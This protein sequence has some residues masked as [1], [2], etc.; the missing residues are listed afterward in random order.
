MSKAFETTLTEKNQADPNDCLSRYLIRHGYSPDACLESLTPDASTRKYFRIRWNDKTAVVA[1]YPDPFDPVN[2]SFLD[3]T[4]LL[5]KAGLPV[6]EILDVD[7][8]EGVIVQEDLGD[9]QL[10]WLIQSADDRTQISY[11]EKAICLIAKIQAATQLAKDENSIASHLAFDEEKLSWE[12]NF[13]FAHYFKSLRG[14]S[15]SSP[16]E[17]EL[18]QE[19]D[20]ISRELSGVKRVL[21]HRDFH[22]A[23][24]MVDSSSILRVVDYQDARMGPA[25]YDLVS[26]LLDRQPSPPSD[27]Q[28]RE[29]IKFFLLEREKIGLTSLDQNSFT[30]E[31]HLMTL[32]RELK[33]AG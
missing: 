2:Q 14:E 24:L 6:P 11:I 31:F 18:R 33:A 25:S 5:R 12:L 27:I 22:T 20:Q 26:L 9:Q 8:Q 32:Q 19:L 10:H 15:L 1:V 17:T 23:N 21:C 16:Q 4:N 3:V 28:I 7:G 29:W 30:S 13:F